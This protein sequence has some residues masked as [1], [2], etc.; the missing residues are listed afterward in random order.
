MEVTFLSNGIIAIF[1]SEA[2]YAL[3]LAE[4]FNLKSGLNYSVSVFTDYNSLKNYVSENYI[5]ILLISEEFCTY[6]E[7]F[8][9]VPNIFILTEGNIYTALKE[10]ASLY[11]Y[12]PTD[13]ILRDVMSC[14]A[15]YSPGENKMLSTA[16]PAKI[17]GIY[18]PVKRCGKTSFA[19]AYGCISSLTENCLY[20]N[21]EEY[22][23][24]S[25]FV[26]DV[27]IGDLSD[28]LYFYRQN[29]LNI[30]KKLIA[31][32][33]TYH[34]LN[35][36]PPMQFSYDIKNM[37]TSDLNNFIQAIA[38]T[39]H[40]QNI[41]LDISDSLKDVPG[42]LNICDKIFMP[43]TKDPISQLKVDDFFKSIAALCSSSIKDKTEILTL[44]YADPHIFSD[45]D[46]KDTYSSD[47][48][49]NLLFSEFGN[50][51]REFLKS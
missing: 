37:E 13:S 4:Y 36:I 29:P 38:E 19:L 21:F 34:N 7:E 8:Q 10:Y 42:I 15:S 25:F 18:S 50:Y 17:T 44:P 43:T 16:S 28:L 47:F 30:D 24:F 35:Y 5:E 20:I 22:S 2:D 41:I 46:Q 14:Y 26:N 39:E 3:K 32:S 48:M 49:E 27:P 31:L 6:I 51:I 40:F 45:S 12:Q 33:H 11:K 1:D 23:G 9:N